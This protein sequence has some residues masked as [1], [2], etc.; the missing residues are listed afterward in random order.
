MANQGGDSLQ[1]NS[2]TLTSSLKISQYFLKEYDKI[3][4]PKTLK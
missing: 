3:H 1:L 2:A 4:N